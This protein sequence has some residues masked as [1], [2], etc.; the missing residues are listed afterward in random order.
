M[1]VDRLEPNYTTDI[2]TAW[3]HKFY[4]RLVKYWTRRKKKVQ[5]EICLYL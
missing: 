4:L 5:T 1:E 3:L 2:E